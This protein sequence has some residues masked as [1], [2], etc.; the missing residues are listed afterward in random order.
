M[1]GKKLYF[2]RYIPKDND[3]RITERSGFI[4]RTFANYEDYFKHAS[5]ISP[6]V[7]EPKDEQSK[8]FLEELMRRI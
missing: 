4:K 5:D 8:K 3:Y 2:L 7:L 6:H 1:S